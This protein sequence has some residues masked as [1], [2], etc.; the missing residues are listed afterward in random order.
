[1]PILVLQHEASCGLGRMAPILRDHAHRVDLRRL[2]LPPARNAQHLPPDLDNVSG[3]IILGGSMNVGDTARYT[4]LNDEIALIR[5]AHDRQLPLLGICLGHQ[6]I[7]HAL[8]G[9]VGPADKPEWGFCPVNLAPPGQTDTL[10]AGVPWAHRQFQMHQQ[11]VRKLPEGATPLISSPACKV[12]AF[13]VGLRTYGFQFHFEFTR[14]MIDAAIRDSANQQDLTAA[15]LTTAQASAQLAEHFDT[16]DRVG[17]R[18]IN[19]FAAFMFP[20]IAKIRR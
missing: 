13:K 11:E 6:L 9:E 7:A 3:V 2:D 14:E 19:N 4:W 8:G 15:G 12:Q 20:P 18:L 16:F 10:L 1:M 5:A 17:T